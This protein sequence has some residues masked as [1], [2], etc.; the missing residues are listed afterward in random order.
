MR[1]HMQTR[2]DLDEPVLLVMKRVK[3]LS[4]SLSRDI[5]DVGKSVDRLIDVTNHRSVLR[6]EKGQGKWLD[7]YK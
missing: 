2:Q 7:G 1:T 3:L 4:S 6:G 5:Q